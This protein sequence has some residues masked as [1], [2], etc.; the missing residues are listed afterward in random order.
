MTQT[1]VRALTELFEGRHGLGL[2]QSVKDLRASV[3][4]G[5]G[6]V[7]DVDTIGDSDSRV[8]IS[9]VAAVTAGG[10]V[11]LAATLPTTP[12]PRTDSGW[13]QGLSFVGWAIDTTGDNIEDYEV[14]VFMSGPRSTGLVVS[15][16]GQT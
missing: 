9:E 2:A 1:R 11:R 5:P 4:N 3:V 6:T 10:R 13:Q 14:G 15:P 12:D 7:S 16:D 8:D